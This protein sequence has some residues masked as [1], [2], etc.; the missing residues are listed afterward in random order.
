MPRFQ[1]SNKKCEKHI[2]IDLIPHV[3]FIWS[4]I[5]NR[6]ESDYDQCPVCGSHREIVKEYEG[7]TKIWFKAENARNYQNKKVINNP[8]KFNY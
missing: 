4:S 2:N 8:R 7:F 1:C 5:N 6:L 3:K